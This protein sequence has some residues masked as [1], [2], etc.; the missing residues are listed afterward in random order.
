LDIN[1]N[2][3]GITTAISEGEGISFALPISQEFIDSTLL[4]LE[5]F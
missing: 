5:T 4:S 2:V 1:G 3:I